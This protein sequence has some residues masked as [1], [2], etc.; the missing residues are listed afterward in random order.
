MPAMPAAMSAGRNRLPG[1]AAPR[2]N[3]SRVAH[4]AWALLLKITKVTGAACSTAVWTSMP[5]MKNA[6][7][8][9]ITYVRCPVA[10]AA[11]MPAPK[12]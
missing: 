1:F 2:N 7:S 6:P 10:S 8:P 9:A 11:P 12:V 5:C 3:C 4:M